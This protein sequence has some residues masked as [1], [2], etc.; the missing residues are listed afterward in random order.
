MCTNRRVDLCNLLE[1]SCDILVDA[2]ILADDNSKIVVAHDGS[3]VRY[4]K[5]NPRVEIEIERVENNE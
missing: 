1:A 5:Q 2:G 3:R 4:D